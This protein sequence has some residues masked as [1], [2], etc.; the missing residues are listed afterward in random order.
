MSEA[1]YLIHSFYIMEIDDV[2]TKFRPY[3]CGSS[4]QLSSLMLIA[5]VVVVQTRSSHVPA[6]VHLSS[7]WTT[8]RA[9]T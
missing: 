2:G 7:K 3:Y 9:I 6:V 1:R 5:E 4:Q 8:A